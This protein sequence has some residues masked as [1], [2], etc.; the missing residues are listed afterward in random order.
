MVSCRWEWD[1]YQCMWY[2]K[3]SSHLPTCR[4]NG[5]THDL[6]MN[7]CACALKTIILHLLTHKIPGMPTQAPNELHIRHSYITP[8]I[9]LLKH[10]NVFFFLFLSIF[11][12][13][14][15]VDMQHIL[16]TT[17]L[18]WKGGIFQWPLCC[19][20]VIFSQG[21][22]PS[23]GGLEKERQLKSST[24]MHMNTHRCTEH[25]FGLTCTNSSTGYNSLCSELEI[26]GH[27]E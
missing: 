13:Q 11:V 20:T 25:A 6:Y 7:M 24:S 12:A 26:L 14:T 16:W 3:L 27:S 18:L 10:R 22:Q 5:A 19:Q 23:A 2:E 21:Q 1:C 8:H 17:L 15:L 4:V 9:V